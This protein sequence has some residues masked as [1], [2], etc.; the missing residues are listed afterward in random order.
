MEQNKQENQQA[1]QPAT[2]IVLAKPVQTAYLTGFG[3]KQIFK[4]SQAQI[5]KEAE[6]EQ[7]FQKEVAS[8]PKLELK[9]FTN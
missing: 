7:Q 6:Q 8:N 9:S 3:G 4:K 1:T 5:Q 2:Q